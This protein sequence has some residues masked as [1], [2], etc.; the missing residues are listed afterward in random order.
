VVA[1]VAE[2][3][4]AGSEGVVVVVD[5]AVGEVVAVDEVDEVDVVV[6]DVVVEPKKFRR[7]VCSCSGST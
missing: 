6:V 5:D 2:V 4:V 3:D 7:S 1:L